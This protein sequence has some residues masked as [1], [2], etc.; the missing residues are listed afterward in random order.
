MSNAF[1]RAWRD[2]VWIVKILFYICA[3]IVMSLF[4]YSVLPESLQNKVTDGVLKTLG[5]HELTT[6]EIYTSVEPFEEAPRFIVGHQMIHDTIVVKHKKPMCHPAFY[7]VN[8]LRRASY[9]YDI[10]DGKVE[11]E[12]VTEKVEHENVPSRVKGYC[13]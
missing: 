2:F 4:L 6:T 10:A 9:V 11:I 13:D 1:S 7:K 3:G 12:F 8:F 5:Q